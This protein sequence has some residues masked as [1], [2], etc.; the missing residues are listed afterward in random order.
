MIAILQI[1]HKRSRSSQHMGSK[2]CPMQSLRTL[3]NSKSAGPFLHNYE[4]PDSGVD[5]ETELDTG[6][7]QAIQL[8]ASHKMELLNTLAMA[9]SILDAPPQHEGE[10]S[11]NKRREKASRPF[12]GFGAKK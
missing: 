10:Q 12:K 8:R 1:A 4:V 9:A 5:Q 11:K 7:L 2:V 6:R 3:Q